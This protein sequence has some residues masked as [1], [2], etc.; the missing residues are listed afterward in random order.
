MSRFTSYSDEYLFILLK[1][2][3]EK[4]FET[5][6]ERYWQK[7]FVVAAKRLESASEAEEI[8]QDIFFNIW[9][10]R[11]ELNIEKSVAAYLSASVR[12]QV[13][14]GLAKRK[15]L[16]SFSLTIADRYPSCDNAMVNNTRMAELIELLQQTVE[17]LPQQCKL[18]Y[19]LSREQGYNRKEIAET[20]H[21]SEKTVANHL[22][23]AL[24][25]LRTVLHLSII[26]FMK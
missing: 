20:L 22:T 5:L 10:L 17:K 15:R 24:G 14:N 9:K 16:R 3:D 13:F 19:R 11:F 8:V 26:L 25:I 6:Y 1:N 2:S 23:R 12:F 18:V 7:L 4:A 21:L